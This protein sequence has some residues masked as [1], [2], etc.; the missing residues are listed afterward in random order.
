MLLQISKQPIWVSLPANRSV[1]IPF[2][3]LY[4]ASTLAESKCFI[5]QKFNVAASGTTS[6]VH[7]LEGKNWNDTSCLYTK[8]D[9]TFSPHPMRKTVPHKHTPND[10]NISSE[11]YKP[12]LPVTSIPIA[13][14]VHLCTQH[15]RLTYFLFRRTS[16]VPST[17]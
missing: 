12:K 2:L 15:L 1:R 17:V 8:K 5:L 6:V 3:T 4:P 7:F 13:L 9:L 14:A 10:K 16:Y 11:V